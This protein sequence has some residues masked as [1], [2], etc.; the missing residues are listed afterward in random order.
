M[1]KKV[2]IQIRKW[3]ETLSGLLIIILGIGLIIIPFTVDTEIA[4]QHKIIGLSLVITAIF[5]W[6]LF[7]LGY[8]ILK[9][10]STQEYEL[11]GKR[12]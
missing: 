1:T 7:L 12:I 5:G 6:I 11:N 4:N 10:K 9:N 8:Y 2:Y 3:D